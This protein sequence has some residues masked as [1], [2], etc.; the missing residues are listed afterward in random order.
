[1][2]DFSISINHLCTP[3]PRMEVILTGYSSREA[4]TKLLKGVYEAIR[5]PRITIPLLQTDLDELRLDTQNEEFEELY[6]QTSEVLLRW[7]YKRTVYRPGKSDIAEIDRMNSD[8][9]WM[10]KAQEDIWDMIHQ[11]FSD[12]G[13]GFHEFTLLAGNVE[14]ADIRAY[15]AV[16]TNSSLR[17]T[18]PYPAPRL[19]VFRPSFAEDTDRPILL[20]K[21]LPKIEFGRSAVR[22]IVPTGNISDPVGSAFA[23]IVSAICP[24]Q[25][26]ATL[27]TK[28]QLGYAVG[29][30]KYS[31][32]GENY[33]AFVVQTEKLNGTATLGRIQNWIQ[34]W[35][36]MGLGEK[37]EYLEIDGDNETTTPFEEHFD[38]FKAGVV[39]EWESKHPSLRTKTDEQEATLLWHR[40]NPEMYD[41]I[42]TAL[43]NMS[44]EQFRSLIGTYFGA[45]QDWRAV[46]LDG[47]AGIETPNAVSLEGWDV[48]TEDELDAE[49]GA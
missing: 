20:H 24:G 19:D 27:R 17:P 37:D 46:V 4:T 15:Q 29:S 48:V 49:D 23:D 41:Q 16:R 47:S 42:L 34:N 12:D 43:R 9:L 14:E 22:M 35:I 2:T 38:R 1:M 18:L 11:V 21:S 33:H 5:W 26:F 6:K 44:R 28:E 3:S 10:A 8:P 36:V 7:A 31:L 40:D 32:S 30:F 13:Q 45:K 39:A 25:F